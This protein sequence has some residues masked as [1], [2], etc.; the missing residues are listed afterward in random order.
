[1][2]SHYEVLGLAPDADRAAVRRAYR[3]LSKRHHPD[4]GGSREEFRRIVEAYEA[5]TGNRATDGR[6]AVGGAIE[7]TTD[8]PTYPID[9]QPADATG[10]LTV[11]GEYLRLTLAGL[12]HEMD[13]A[14]IV[15]DAT[16]AAT[17]RTVA[18]F[19]VENHGDRSVTW[20]GR[21][22]TSFVGD[23]GFMYEGSNVVSPH[24]DDVPGRWWARTADLVP[25]RG[26]DALVVA[27]AIPGD[28][29][30]ETVVY[31][32]H[33]YDGEDVSD[34]ERYL[35]EVRPGVRTALDRPPFEL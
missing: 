10:G 11:D 3:T 21:Q 2:E 30:V 32:H 17:D 15:G 27:Q 23:D 26:L 13:L 34:T 16:S 28:V 19:E 8:A 18:F 12:V 1:M 24:S 20:R 9:S 35:F 25:D 33:V 6:D 7:T 29:R 22:N 5:I 4:H 14:P 31:T